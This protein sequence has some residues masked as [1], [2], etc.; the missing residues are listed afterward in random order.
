MVKSLDFI[1]MLIAVFTSARRRSNLF[2]GLGCAMA[3][4]AN[5]RNMVIRSFGPKLK[6]SICVKV[7]TRELTQKPA[8]QLTLSSRK[9]LL[10]EEYPLQHVPRTRGFPTRRQR[11]AKIRA[12]SRKKKGQS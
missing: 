5:Q 8:K 2:A 3:C 9:S 7:K 12:K 6:N 1:E 10:I 11:N 4:E